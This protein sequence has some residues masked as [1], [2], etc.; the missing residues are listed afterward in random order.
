MYY[1]ECMA[2]NAEI[3][4]LKAE[5]DKID[6]ESTS[7]ALIIQKQ[8]KEMEDLRLQNIELQKRNE[9]LCS[10]YCRNRKK[11][12]KQCIS[13]VEQAKIKAVKEF[14]E[15]CMDGVG[16]GSDERII[17]KYLD[18]LIKENEK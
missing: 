2:L 1:S 13:K 3:E 9:K 18:E 17:K 4:R 15:K 14:A 11:L 5:N 7:Y 8:E 10:D 16:Y 12:E 6:K